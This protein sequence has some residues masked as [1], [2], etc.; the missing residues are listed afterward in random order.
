MGGFTPSSPLPNGGTAGQ[1][2]TVQS[3]NPR[4]LEWANGGAVPFLYAFG[5]I[6]AFGNLAPGSVGIT[7]ATFDGGDQTYKIDVSAAG[8]TV[9]PVTVV[10]PLK[11]PGSQPA[12]MDADNSSAFPLIVVRVS[13]TLGA[14]DGSQGAFSIWCI[15]T[16]A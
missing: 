9:P 12:V 16:E 15:N 11:S 5:Q 13:Q 8:F 6:D 1:V 14:F 3:D 10:S 4:V 2:L 7:S